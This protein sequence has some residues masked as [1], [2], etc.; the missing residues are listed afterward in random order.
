MVNQRSIP[1]FFEKEKSARCGNFDFGKT[2][3]FIKSSSAF[4]SG[5]EQGANLAQIAAFFPD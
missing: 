1:P 4:F 3:R 5:G 2:E